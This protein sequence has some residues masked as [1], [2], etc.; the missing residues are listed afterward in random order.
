MD[1]SKVKVHHLPKKVKFFECE[2][3]N[4]YINE[5]NV[6]TF[7]TYK[8]RDEQKL[9]ELHNELS[10]IESELEH[11]REEFV[12]EDL[13]SQRKKLRNDIEFAQLDEFEQPYQVKVTD[14][15][16]NSFIDFAKQARKDSV[17]SVAYAT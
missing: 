14:A 6:I 3:G 16:F 4:F 15:Q 5:D 8:D 12:R 17:R 2:N 9:L 11:V 1:L 13:L 7:T 10:A